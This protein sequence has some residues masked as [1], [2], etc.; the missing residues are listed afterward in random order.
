M[1]GLFT[2]C[3]AVLGEVVLRAMVVLAVVATP[4]LVVQAITAGVSFALETF[5]R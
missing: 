2:A 3:A 4:V 5:G 1:T